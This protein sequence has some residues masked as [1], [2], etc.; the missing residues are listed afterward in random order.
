MKLKKDILTRLL[1]KGA[2]CAQEA[3]AEAPPAGDAASVPDSGAGGGAPAAEPSSEPPAESGAADEGIDWGG[4]FGD[5]DAGETPPAEPP[6]SD[7]EAAP[8][9]Q[10]AAPAEP[11]VPPQG[12]PAEPT[13]QVPPE[14]PPAPEA[15][16]PPTPE[17][18]P[19]A[20]PPQDVQPQPQEPTPEQVAQ[21]QEQV[22]AARA[23]W[24]NNLTQQYALTEE[25]S[26][27]VMTNPGEVLP[28]IMGEMHA[29]MMEHTMQFLRES[30]PGFIDQSMNFRSTRDAGVESFFKEW[31]ELREH[32]PLMWEL[33]TMWRERNPEASTEEF[34]KQVGPI[35]WSAAGLSAQDLINR[36]TGSEGQPPAVP[37]PQPPAGGYS[38]APQQAGASPVAP[39]A[40]ARDNWAGDLAGRWM[41]D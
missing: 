13:S 31:P 8:P 15:T 16:V 38:P 34:I 18:Q 14:A 4:V 1:N 3:V 21:Y 5:D 24:V 39:P 32:E 2:I 26:T 28:Q 37:A 17:Q 9:V 12:T 22:Q 33:G 25:Q 20:E 40:D 30:L 29:R 36:Q 6:S 11:Q 7:T 10:D 19:P 27:A 35:V 41:D 23:E